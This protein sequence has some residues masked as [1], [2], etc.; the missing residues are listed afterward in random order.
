M[1]NPPKQVWLLTTEAIGRQGIE[2]ALESGTAHIVFPRLIGT[3]SPQCV[4][5]VGLQSKGEDIL[6]AYFLPISILAPSRVPIVSAPFRANF[7]LPVPDA[8]VPAMEICSLRS[9]AGMIFS[10]SDTR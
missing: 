3:L 6:F 10:A 5:L 8:S 9:A 2:D 1:I 4:N 7:M